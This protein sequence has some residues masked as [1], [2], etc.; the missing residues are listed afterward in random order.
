MT[1]V[2]VDITMS[3]DGFVAGPNA[4]LEAPLGVGGERLHEWV[5]KL[6]TWRAAHGLEGGETG[7]DADLV[8]ASVRATG[9][10]VMGRRMFSGGAGP[11][12]D[13]PNANGWWG[14]EPPFGHAVFVL[15]HHERKPLVLGD[16]T[17]TFVTTG[18]DRAIAD[19]QEAAGGLDV[20]VA[21]GGD[22]V[23]QALR[24]GAVE[25]LTIHIAPVLL[26]SGVSLFGGVDVPL[27]LVETIPSAG[28]THLRYR[29]S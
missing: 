1:K 14:D 20:R 29:V 28:V 22:V 5:T 25:E 11:W 24:A 9:A 6:A 18:I 23:Q 17:F 7:A 3:L 12:E 4:S 26:G 8:E 27:E 16:T 10:T 15:T 19:A 13:D 21:G 2:V